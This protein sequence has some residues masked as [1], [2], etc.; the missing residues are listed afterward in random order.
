[1]AQGRK[2][3]GEQGRRQGST[4]PLL[5]GY[6]L[7][8]RRPRGPATLWLPAL[9]AGALVWPPRRQAVRGHRAWALLP[10]SIC[11]VGGCCRSGHGTQMRGEITGP[12]GRQVATAAQSRGSIPKFLEAAE[13]SGGG[14]F[15]GPAWERVK[16]C[17]PGRG[18]L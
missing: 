6:D 2:E 15:Q 16:A 13:S 14:S 17:Q 11:K 3:Q 9:L 12:R 10:Y 8:G 4:A 1:M 18:L 5:Q 7:E